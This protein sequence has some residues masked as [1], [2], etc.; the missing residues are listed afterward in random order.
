MR[1]AAHISVSEPLILRSNERMYLDDE[2]LS[3]SMPRYITFEFATVV[4]RLMFT[5][6][7]KRGAS[8]S[9]ISGKAVG[10]RLQNMPGG[11]EGLTARNNDLVGVVS[12]G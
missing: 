9:G 12:R 1:P 10:H 4:V 7:K 6:V 3:P 2:A 8:A 11:N 5:V